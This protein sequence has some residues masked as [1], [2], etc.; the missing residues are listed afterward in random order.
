VVLQ[1]LVILFSGA[2]EHMTKHPVEKAYLKLAQMFGKQ[3]AKEA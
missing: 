3:E 2:L 1:G